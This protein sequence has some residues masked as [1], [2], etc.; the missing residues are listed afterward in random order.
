MTIVAKPRH[1]SPNGFTLVELLVVIAIVAALSAIGAVT[2]GK[3]RDKADSVASLSNL[4]QIGIGMNLYAGDNNSKYPFAWDAPSNTT[5][6]DL[7]APYAGSDDSTPD[8]IYVSPTS[9]LKIDSSNDRVATYAVN[10][11]M[12]WSTRQQGDDAFEPPVTTLRVVDPA[13]TIIVADTGQES[14]LGNSSQAAFTAASGW[15]Y[16][17]PDRGS[18]LD[19]PIPV[20]DANESDGTVPGDSISYRD[21][22]HA[23]CL[24]ADGTVRRFAKGTITKGNMVFHH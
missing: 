20:S 23:A 22:G 8:S 24:M 3:A 15:W 14:G 12:M 19:D 9:V 10:S 1:K 2:V 11:E 18:W 16:W 17:D 21:N 5:W 4:R 7:I 13:N 6:R